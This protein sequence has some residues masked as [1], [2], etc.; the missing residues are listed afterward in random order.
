M[1]LLWRGDALPPQLGSASGSCLPY[2]NGRS[3]GDVCLNPGGLVL[4]CRGLRRLMAFDEETGTLRCE[5]GVLLSEV[6]DF[7]VPRGWFLPVTPGTRFVTVGGAIANDV[8]G[9]NHHNAGT[10]GCHVSQL[11]L[12]R[13]DGSRLLCSRALNPE[14]FGGT[15]GG[16][17]LTG[18]ITWAEF[19]LKPIKS[20]F[21]EQETLRFGNLRGFHG[22]ARESDEAFEYTVAWI[23]CTARG[24]ALG[25]GVFL[26]GNHA[27]GPGSG[28]RSAGVGPPRL[29]IPFTPPFSMVNSLSVRLFNALYYRR[30]PSKKKE[31]RVHFGPFFYPLDSLGDWNRVY[32]GTGFL[33]YQCVIPLAVAEP[34]IAEILERVALA[35][36][37]SFLAVLKRFGDL[38][39][40]GL[41]SFPREGFT[42]ALDFPN[43]GSRTLELLDRLDEVTVKAGGAV[44]PSK[45]ARMS[46]ETFRASFPHW[47]R[48]SA[49]RDPGFSSAFWRRVTRTDSEP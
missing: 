31:K 21:I 13:T 12:L 10:F 34:A 16:L 36:E 44:N 19:R 17:G 28:R 41:L 3:Y 7:S 42:L 25:R 45:D 40:P 29:R 8:H 32:G 33:Q 30:A 48:V 18:V 23:D 43:R 46:P 47:E 5:A 22:I 24:A 2:G 14:W 20:P 9:K 11:E 26:R 38:P 15:I 39:S 49:L 6:L 35:G 27:Q 1:K 4:D 37:G